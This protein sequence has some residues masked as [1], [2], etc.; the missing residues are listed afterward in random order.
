MRIILASKSPRR[1]EILEML[2]LKFEIIVSEVDETSDITDPT[3]LVRE[4]AQ[5]KGL[6]VLNA[7]KAAGE[8]ISDV[9]IIS[10]DTLV[11]CGDEILGKPTDRADGERML[12]LMSG[13]EHTVASGVAAIYGGVSAVDSD[14][15]QVRFSQMSD[16][17]I[18][19]YLNTN[20][21]ADKAGAYA[22]QGIAALYIDGIDGDYFNVVGLPLRRL[23]LLLHDAFGIDLESLATAD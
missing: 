1:R 16:D 13:R 15:T 2:G 17:E 12:R 14:A 8:D 6:A 23:K 7:L 19:F 10:S 4:L 21:Y 18:S 3:A 22:V 11:F 20:E 9:L 5:R